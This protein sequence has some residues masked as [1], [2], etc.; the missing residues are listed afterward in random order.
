MKEKEIP[1]YTDGRHVIVTSRELIVDSATYL[2][3]SIS[4]VR[5]HF[6]RHF[7]YPPLTL[8]IAGI[9]L[10]IAGVSGLFHNVRLEELY[11]MDILITS[12]RLFSIVGTI[13]SLMGFLWLSILHN[14]YVLIISTEEGVFYP[15]SRRKKEELSKIV[16]VL[17]DAI[18]RFK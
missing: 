2:L 4:N 6:V 15:L 9:L 5:L 18:H 14:E 10:L 1:I 16:K 17:T 11:I 3:N 13:L 7:K 12:D 8:I